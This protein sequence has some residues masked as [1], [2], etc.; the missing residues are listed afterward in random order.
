MKGVTVKKPKADTGREM[1]G[2]M[3]ARRPSEPISRTNLVALLSNW[4]R[5][6]G[7][8]GMGWRAAFSFRSGKR[9][10]STPLVVVRSWYQKALAT[11]LKL[12][13]RF[14]QLRVTK[15]F[16]STRCRLRCCRVSLYS[17]STLSSETP[18]M[19]ALAMSPGAMTQS[20]LKPYQPRVSDEPDTLFA[21][22][23]SCTTKPVAD[24]R[25]VLLSTYRYSPLRAGPRLEKAARLM[26][27]SWLS[28]IA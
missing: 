7:N 4:Y 2:W 23:V 10:S 21:R 18:L 20:C 9:Y 14:P 11:K 24:P 25:L 12:P 1:R 13:S 8:P 28:E 15:T 16:D 6:P 17:R 19:S 26:V 3:S 22:S 5:N 27:A